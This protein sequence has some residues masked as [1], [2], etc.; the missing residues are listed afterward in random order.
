[1]ID[2]DWDN[3]EVRIFIRKNF[4]TVPARTMFYRGDGSSHTYRV[5]VVVHASSFWD[6]FVEDTIYAN[7]ELEEIPEGTH[8]D[9]GVSLTHYN[10]GP[11]LKIY[12]RGRVLYPCLQ[13]RVESIL[14]RRG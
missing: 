12:G 2:F 5:P 14:S 6:F 8:V 1:M 4:F 10:Q 3:H 13:E 9:R 11:M 7:T